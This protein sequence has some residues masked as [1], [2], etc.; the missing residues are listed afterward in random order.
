MDWRRFEP[1][2]SPGAGCAAILRVPVRL[3]LSSHGLCAARWSAQSV[4]LQLQHGGCLW[5]AGLL[6]AERLSDYR[7]VAE[8]EGDYGQGPCEG[9]LCAPHSAHM[10]ALFCCVLWARCF[11]PCA[12]GSGAC[13]SL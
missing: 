11:E 7:T 3:L 2:L 5:S 13:E 10:A 8:G 6:S 1:I 9:V 4:V 12:A